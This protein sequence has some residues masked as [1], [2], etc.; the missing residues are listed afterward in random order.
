MKKSF[1]RL[2]AD[3]MQ[4]LAI[5]SIL[6]GLFQD[7]AIGLWLGLLFLTASYILTAW[8]VKS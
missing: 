1:L 3:T 2:T 8:E 5:G 7:H 4:K 6:V